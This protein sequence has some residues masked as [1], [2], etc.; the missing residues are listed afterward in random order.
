LL[1]LNQGDFKKEGIS[2]QF[3]LLIALIFALLVAA[4]AIQNAITVQ[5]VLFTW[6]FKTSLVLIIFG[7]AILGALSVGLFSL[8]QFIQWKVKL[9]RKERRIIELE[10]EIDKLSDQKE[11]I[12]GEE[13]E[14][15]KLEKE[16]EKEIKE[17]VDISNE[18][19]V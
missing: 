2:L 3:I 6:Q 19:E 10:K 17:E 18:Q 1:L 12:S 11:L 8:V 9:K 4:F 15:K 5:V 14:E 13:S 7:S 16:I